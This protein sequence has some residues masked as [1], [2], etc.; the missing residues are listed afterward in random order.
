MGLLFLFDPVDLAKEI[1]K[2]SKMLRIKLIVKLVFKIFFNL[3]LLRD[4]NELVDVE[5]KFYK[6]K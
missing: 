6:Y 4:W 1:E 5:R 3:R 2:K